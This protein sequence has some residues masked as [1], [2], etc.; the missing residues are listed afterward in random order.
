MTTATP[1]FDPEA[2]MDMDPSPVEVRD[3][4]AH[5]ASVIPT[6]YQP[7]H[8]DTARLLDRA[9][10]ALAALQSAV[11]VPTAQAVA[12]ALEGLRGHAYH[13]PLGDLANQLVPVGWRL[14]RTARQAAAG[15]CRLGGEGPCDSGDR[16]T[17]WVYDDLA[18]DQDPGCPRHAAKEALRWD[19]GRS[20]EVF[21]VGADESCRATIARLNGRLSPLPLWAATPPGTP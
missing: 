20:V 19:H 8:T 15:G 13:R 1:E 9:H 11:D 14:V 3:L 7:P 6:A 5:L 18:I 17:V 16:V 10:V 4:A 21:L 12:E 2:W